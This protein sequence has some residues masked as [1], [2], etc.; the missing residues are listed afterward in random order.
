MSQN[1]K[2]GLMGCGRIAQFF[3]LSILGGTPGVRL[4]AIAE[5]SDE[6]RSQAKAAAPDAEAYS[7]YKDLLADENVD[8]VVVCL[9]T[10][11]H[12]RAAIDAFEAGKHVYLE[13]PIGIT[14]DEAAAV[15]A[16]EQAS[17]KTG[18]IGFNYRFH[19][20]HQQLKSRMASGEIGNLVG[21]RSCFC[22][23]KRELPGW[24]QKRATGGGVLLDLGTHH[25]DLARF[26]FDDEVVG[27]SGAVRGM[28]YEGDFGS[29]RMTLGSGLVWDGSFSSQASH[30]DTI[31]VL[32]DKGMLRLDRYAG[33]LERSE[34]TPGAGLGK[35]GKRAVAGVQELIK[36][37]VSPA[38]EPSFKGA[39]TAWAASLSSGG[40]PVP[41]MEGMH[42]LSVVCAAERSAE[43]GGGVI[44]PR[45]LMETP[46]VAAA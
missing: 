3:H 43:E 34:S 45:S 21:V 39:L 24:K 11:M 22:A 35:R 10:G 42:S 19:P 15:L 23:E 26:L 33:S 38:G 18:T 27:V 4:T 28:N 29:M 8:A 41:L 30:T 5:M 37:T 1:A 20:L 40:A 31:E 12:A 9:P 6:L 2:V 32:G 46:A 17:G 36:R 25:A 16:A 14:M 44:D 7:D 13:K